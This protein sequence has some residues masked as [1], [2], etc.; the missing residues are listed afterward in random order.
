MSAPACTT[1]TAHDTAATLH[2]RPRRT[3]IESRLADCRANVFVLLRPS[4]LPAASGMVRGT[5]HA[6]PLGC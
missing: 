6:S 1:H 4:P 3:H 2:A 5:L